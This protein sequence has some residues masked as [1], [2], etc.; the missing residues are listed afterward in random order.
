M[1]PGPLK[2]TFGRFTIAVAFAVAFAYIESAV[3]VYLREIFYPDGFSFPLANLPSLGAHQRWLLL[4][5]VGREAATIVLILT[6]AHLF[7]R[8]CAQRFAYCLAVF[9][10]WDIFY[11]AWLKLLLDWPASI[12]EWD[13]LFLIPLPWAAPVLCPVVVSAMMAV[14]SAV[15]LWRDAVGRPIKATPRDWVLSALAGGIIILS[16]C[17]AGPYVSRADYKAHFYW[18]LFAAGCILAGGVF[19]CCLAKSRRRS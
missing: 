9:A 14:F 13:L 4:V 6:G 10:V 11:Y 7:G 8:N 12:L 2:T 19:V 3:V 16:L 18:P 15:I 1:Q 5:E 17:T